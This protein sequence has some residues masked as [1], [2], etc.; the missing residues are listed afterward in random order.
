MHQTLSPKDFIPR[1]FVNLVHGN[2]DLKEESVQ[3]THVTNGIIIQK[4]FNHDVQPVVED[5]TEHE[6]IKKKQRPLIGITPYAVGVKRHRHLM[7]TLWIWRL[8]SLG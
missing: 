5:C 3:Q 6:P 2:I 8:W 7:A 1:Q 4:V